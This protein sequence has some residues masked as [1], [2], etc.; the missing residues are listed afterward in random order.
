MWLSVKS[1]SKYH[2]LTWKQA[3]NTKTVTTKVHLHSAR[4][5][6]GST[7][8][9]SLFISP[10]SGHLAARQRTSVANN[11]AFILRKIC[12]APLCDSTVMWKP[13][14]AG[15]WAGIGYEI[16]RTWIERNLRS[17]RVLT[18]ETPKQNSWMLLV[19]WKV[20]TSN[21]WCSSACDF[22]STARECGWLCA[23]E[24]SPNNSPP[25]CSCHVSCWFSE[26][27]ICV[28]I[29]GFVSGHAEPNVKHRES[30]RIHHA[31]DSQRT[32]CDNRTDCSSF[33][34]NSVSPDA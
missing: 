28:S 5:K 11:I 24:L 32:Y 1:S 20:H 19:D 30:P 15:H 31:G 25:L 8:I 17:K 22:T 34:F 14:L 18:W 29:M 21:S 33:L 13:P 2:H 7:T 9:N 4:N 12:C 6:Q 10:C 26:I 3:I 23:Q 27:K 16:L